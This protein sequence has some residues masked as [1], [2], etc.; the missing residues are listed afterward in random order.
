MNNDIKLSLTVLVPGAKM[1]SKE[2]SFKNPKTKNRELK[3]VYENIPVKQVIKMT[4]EA[5]NNFIS[6]TPP[7]EF[8]GGAAYWASNMSK[9]AKIEWHCNQIAEHLNGKLESFQILDD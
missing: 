9:L 8:K 6:K 4:Y 3:V 2:V 1:R 7:S 5:Y